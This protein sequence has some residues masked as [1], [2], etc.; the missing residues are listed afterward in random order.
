MRSRRWS[1]LQIGKCVGEFEQ[2]HE[3]KRRERILSNEKFR[4]RPGRGV[5]HACKCALAAGRGFRSENASVNLNSTT[6]AS[7]AS[8]SFRT[9]NSENAPAAAWITR[10]NALSPLVAASDRKMRR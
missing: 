7:A 3:G 8:A 5:D 9:R 10:V 6:K 2:H 4:E 1:R